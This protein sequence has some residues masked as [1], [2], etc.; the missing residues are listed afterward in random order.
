MTASN[1]SP[2]DGLHLI[3]DNFQL[4]PDGS[5][6]H[7]DSSEICILLNVQRLLEHFCLP[8]LFVLW[9]QAYPKDPMSE[10]DM[11]DIIEAADPYTNACEIEMSDVQGLILSDLDK[12]GY[13]N[14]CVSIRIL[15]RIVSSNN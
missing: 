3:N 14:L 13:D 6:A 4:F 10:D 15:A 12:A 2:G 9:S 7:G 1:H 8:S 5:Y 11:L